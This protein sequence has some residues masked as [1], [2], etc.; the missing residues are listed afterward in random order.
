MLQWLASLFRPKTQCIP[1]AVLGQAV[2]AGHG[3]SACV[4]EDRRALEALFEKVVVTRDAA[5]ACGVLFLYAT[6]DERGAVVGSPTGLRDIIRDSGAWVVVVAHPNPPEHCFA[7]CAPTGH[8]EANLVFVVDRKGSLLAEFL[9]ALFREMRAGVPMPSAWVRLA[10][11]TPRG[12]PT[13]APET[14]FLCERGALVLPESDRA[15][16]PA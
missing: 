11:Q 5:P 14:I 10:P 7:A 2:F 4:E 3:D 6:I 13:P 12:T 1:S 15:S 8:G 9:G 16:Q